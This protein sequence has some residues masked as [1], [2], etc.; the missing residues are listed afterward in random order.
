MKKI[1]PSFQIFCG[2]KIMIYRNYCPKVEQVKDYY[3]SCKKWDDWLKRNSVVIEQGTSR[4]TLIVSIYL[5]SLIQE[6]VS[7][8]VLTS[9]VYGI[10]WAYSVIGLHLPTDSELVK[11]V[12][13][14]GKRKL[15]IP[16]TKK[17]PITADL[18]KKMYNKYFH[19]ENIY[20]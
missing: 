13:E 4:E 7:V 3:R 8:N 11:N 5:A 1:Y 9:T 20:N 15:S 16:R 19:S 17:E 12:F 14:S 18:L 10:H 6:R 2:E